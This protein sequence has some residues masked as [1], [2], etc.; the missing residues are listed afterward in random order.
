MGQVVCL[1]N[2]PQAKMDSMNHLVRVLGAQMSMA[3]THTCKQDQMVDPRTVSYI[4]RKII[5]G[6]MVKNAPVH[7]RSGEQLGINHC[8]KFLPRKFMLLCCLLVRHEL[9][10]LKPRVVP[11]HQK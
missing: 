9:R 4:Y 10:L 1:K 2:R 5:D 8:P 7:S 6:L 11:S 3:C